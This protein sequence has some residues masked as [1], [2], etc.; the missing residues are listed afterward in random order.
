L[1][2]DLMKIAIWL[3]QSEGGG[4]D[5]HLH[6]LLNNWPIGSDQ[7]CIFTNTDNPSVDSY[8]TI[9][10]SNLLQVVPVRRLSIGRPRKILETVVLPLYVWLTSVSARRKITRFGEFD[11]II[12]YQGCY[13]GSWATMGVLRAA[14]KLDI[15]RRM[16][17]VHHQ[18]SPRRPFLN[19]VESILDRRVAAW[20][21]S[22][23]AVSNATR[24]TLVHRRD[25]DLVVQP[26]RVI[27][28]G[29]DRRVDIARG[30]FRTTLGLGEDWR[31]AAIVGRVELYKGHEELIRSISQL[32]KGVRS[33][34][35]ILIVGSVSKENQDY[36]MNLALRLNVADHVR[37]CGYVAG[38]IS[39]IITDV[40]LLI[41]ATQ[42][43]E[44][45]GYTVLEAMSVG[46][47]VIAT[48]VGAIK[49]FCDER[50][51]IIVRPGSVNELS[52]AISSVFV[53][54]AKTIE[55]VNA[56]KLQAERFSGMKMAN[57]F[58]QE[59]QH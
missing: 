27:H 33:R 34:F 35:V 44:G 14:K 59:L 12:A 6:A 41:C 8:G 46:T 9:R 26:I 48:D 36:L 31:V 16:M 7:I 55:R 45:F 4:V 21:N 10:I 17:L 40:D 39:A 18:A 5:T 37:F 20:A 11:A 23:V 54:T 28:N 58:Y 29:L 43:F 47:P 22:I 50:H 51:G 32:P 42:E 52:E 3:E 13:P 56:A 19:T 25:F 49:E 53:D 2:K 30:G 57:E 1:D 38:E 15:K 24:S